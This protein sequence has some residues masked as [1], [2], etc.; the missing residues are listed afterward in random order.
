MPN[1]SAKFVPFSPLS[2]REI[3]ISLS[4]IKRTDRIRFVDMLSRQLL[5]LRWFK[6]THAHRTDQ[7]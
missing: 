5:P 1:S 4:F 2:K 3:I 7:A 6:R